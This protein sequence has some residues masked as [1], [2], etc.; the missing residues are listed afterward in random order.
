MSA[1]GAADAC[2]DDR[3]GGPA[4]AV[5]PLDDR[6][7]GGFPFRFADPT[8]R[9][10]CRR[11]RAHATPV[12]EFP[13]ESSD[14]VVLTVQVVPFHRSTVARLGGP[15]S[16]LMLRVAKHV[17]G[18]GQATSVGVLLYASDAFGLGTIDQRLPSQRSVSDR[19]VGAPTCSACR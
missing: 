2:A 3:V 18:L 7:D 15:D 14:N 9:D 13:S 16:G 19:V 17:V 6:L 12:N 5:P 8:D 11:G 4:R 1:L 10:A